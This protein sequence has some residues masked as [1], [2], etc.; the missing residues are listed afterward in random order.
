MA[1]DPVDSAL[2]RLKQGKGSAGRGGGPG[3]KYW[4]IYVGEE[5]VG[6]VY[7]NVIDEPPP[8]EHASLQIQINK[9]H[10]GLGIGKIA[11]RLA[12]QGSGHD[13]VYAHMSKKNVAS[14]K[15]AEAAGFEVI[16]DDR[17]RQLLMRWSRT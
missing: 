10:Q 15:A 3:G 13:I 1:K 8:G 4:H 5:R 14:R 11:Y 6:N 9:T 7:V 16:D 12:S 17:I 2:V